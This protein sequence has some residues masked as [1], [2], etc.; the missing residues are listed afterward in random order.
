MHKLLF[1][2]QLEKCLQHNREKSLY[3]KEGRCEKAVCPMCFARHHKNHEFVDLE[4]QKEKCNP[5]FTEIEAFKQ[6]LEERREM[7]LSSRNKVEKR[8][9]DCIAIIL[10]RKEQMLKD[11]NE[12]FNALKKEAEDVTQNTLKNINAEISVVDQHYTALDSIKESINMNTNVL[13]IARTKAS[14]QAMKDECVDLKDVQ[15]KFITYSE[16]NL[17]AD[18]L[19]KLCGR[20]NYLIIDASESDRKAQ[21][22]SRE[23]QIFSSDVKK[24]VTALDVKLTGRK[25]RS[26]S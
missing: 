23:Q 11:V 16:C 24:K 22:I 12:N 4:T 15:P 7:L 26:F 8:N 25:L 14:V 2:G 1:D 13:D 21:S 6:I 3:C 20:L 17:A 9:T 5:L 19:E 10:N 18:C